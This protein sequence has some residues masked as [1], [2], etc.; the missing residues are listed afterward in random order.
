MKYPQPQAGAL[1][2]EIVLQR[3]VKT[4]KKYNNEHLTFLE[5]N[6]DM[7]LREA[8]RIERLRRKACGD[9]K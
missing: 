7:R 4:L 8:I 3:L 6:A 2:R 9:G 5:T 1:D